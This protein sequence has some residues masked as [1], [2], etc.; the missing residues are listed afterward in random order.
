MQET[1]NSIT[2][3]RF[4]EI[5]DVRTITDEKGDPWFFAVDVCR[6]LGLDNTTKAL[7]SLDSDEKSQVVDPDTLNSTEGTGINNLVNIISES[8]LYTL[9]LRC[10][11]AVNPGTLPHR[12]RRWV[13]SEV[14]SERS[15]RSGF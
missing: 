1:V 14:L 13:T 2:V 5:A 15:S 8:G 10:R 7:L 4:E 11:D 9:I 3:F 6:A 12:F